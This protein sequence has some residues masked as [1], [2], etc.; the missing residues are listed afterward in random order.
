MPRFFSEELDGDRVY[1]RG[2]D[3]RHIAKSLRMQP[4]DPLTVCDLRGTD[5][6]CRIDELSPELV[7]LTVLQRLPSETEPTV[8]VRL[9]QALPKGDKLD[10]IVQK[11]V[12]LGVHEIIPVLTSRCVSRPDGKSMEKKI[13]RFSRIALEAAKQSGRG[14]VP[15]VGELRSLE[16]ALAEMGEHPL[17]ILFYEEATQPL[18][19][20]LSAAPDSISILIGA[21]G[22]FSRDE[23][24]AAKA[25]GLRVASLGKRIL[26]CETAPLAA[27]SVLMYETGNL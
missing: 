3:A 2:E 24:E 19:E 13:Q 1:L 16:E 11:A 26:R 10:L 15:K 12:E 21:E 14:I 4:G 7:V 27:L 25:R 18:K 5:L 6:Y 17:A 23:V 9:Y 22:G 8:K 20:M